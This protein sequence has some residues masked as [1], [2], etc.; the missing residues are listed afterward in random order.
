MR[1]IAILIA[2]PL[3]LL[4]SLTSAEPRQTDKKP[5][6]PMEADVRLMDTSTVRTVIVQDK[7]DIVTKYGKLTVPTRDILCIDMG[8]H[9]DPE[10]QA[11]VARLI[12]HLDSEQYKTRE[13]A[14]KDLVEL[15]PIAYP[16][17]C[18][19]V[20]SEKHEVAKRAAMA[21]DKIKAKNP[22]ANLRLR[23][24]DVVT[25]TTFPIHG[26][27]IPPSLRV[28]NGTF[29]EVDLKLTQVR[30]IRWIGASSE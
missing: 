11:Q 16:Q 5:L 3:L 15:G 30:V 4:S 25:T 13:I 21:V 22:P 27:I 18:A 2:L 17:I 6:P 14:L 20:K 19:A 7:I 12:D 23:D 8:V 9:L 10:E 26:C 29:G 1:R 24:F 28:R